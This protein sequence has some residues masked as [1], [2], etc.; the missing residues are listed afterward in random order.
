VRGQRCPPRLGLGIFSAVMFTLVNWRG[1]HRDVVPLALAPV[2][3]VR[4]G[5]VNLDD[6]R[7]Y[8]DEL[9]GPR[10]RL[11]CLVKPGRKGA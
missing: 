4:H 8:Y 9:K 11:A 5:T 3:I 7:A 1:Y 6:F 10:R 2:S